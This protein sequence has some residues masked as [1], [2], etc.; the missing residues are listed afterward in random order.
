MIL[1]VVFYYINCYNYRLWVY[2]R[3]ELA[4]GMK[5]SNKG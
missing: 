1:T 5:Y 4:I 3:Q 2:D